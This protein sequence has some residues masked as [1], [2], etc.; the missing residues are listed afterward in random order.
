MSARV[1][2]VV[3]ARSGSKGIPG[4]NTRTLAGRPLLAYSAVPARESSVVDRL[5][6]STD[7]SEIAAVGREL[8]L[9]VPFLRPP[10]LAGD[11]TPMQPVIEHAV[12]EMERSGWRPDVVVILQPTA[13]LRRPEHVRRAVSLLVESGASSVASV[14]RIPDHFAP[15]YAMRIEGG[16]LTSFLPEGAGLT[17]RQ[18]VEPAYSRDG[19]VYATR[20]DVLVEEGSIYGSDCRPLVLGDDESINLDTPADWERAEAR[21]AGR[22]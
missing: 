6:L 20:R 4:K 15:H 18:E 21:L 13:P 1:L 22:G 2:G 3:P 10:E 12:R 17:R 9:E 8:G 7:S 11:D 14:V 16:R 5:V 19:T